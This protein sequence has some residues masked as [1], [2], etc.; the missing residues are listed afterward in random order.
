[1]SA[2]DSPDRCRARDSLA[3][4][5]RNARC[6]WAAGPRARFPGWLAGSLP[7]SAR[8]SS[9]RPGLPDRPP[10]DRSTVSFGEAPASGAGAPDERAGRRAPCAG[11]V[12]RRSRS[13]PAAASGRGHRP[14]AA[15]SP[16]GGRGP[17]PARWGMSAAPTASSRIPGERPGATVIASARRR[18]SGRRSSSDS[19]LRRQS[20][21]DCAAPR[22]HER[23]PLVRSQLRVLRGLVE[24]H[25]ALPE[26]A[27][28]VGAEASGP[29]PVAQQGLRDEARSR[30][31]ENEAHPGGPV[32]GDR[33]RLVESTHGQE[34]LTTRRRPAHEAPGH[35]VRCS[36]TAKRFSS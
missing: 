18:A 31:V 35:L 20:T 12:G 23:P 3:P 32:V 21:A 13:A 15:K 11:P 19:R 28:P 26:R 4:R 9:D 27:R 30:A 14:A 16:A 10:S 7:K 8:R 2:A 36:V 22:G 5:R 1:M 29:Q 6:T 17:A 34:S 33:K 24:E 25:H